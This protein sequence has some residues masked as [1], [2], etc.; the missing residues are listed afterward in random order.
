MES[1][2]VLRYYDYLAYA[3]DRRYDVRIQAKEIGRVIFVLEFD[4][5]FIVNRVIPVHDTL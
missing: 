5:P 3:L 1:R 2:N 4:Q